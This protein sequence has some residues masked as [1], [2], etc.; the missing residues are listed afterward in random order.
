MTRLG[1]MM[2]VK[3]EAHVIRTC[4]ESVAPL[5]SWWVIADTGSSDGTQQV[6]RDALAG[7]PGELVERPWVDFGHNRQEVLDLARASGHRAPG[8]YVLWIDADEHLEQLP[9]AV[10]ELDLAGYH[11]PVSYGPMRYTRLAVVALDQPWRWVGPIHEYLDLPG[12]PTGEL[13]APVV[14]VEH[15]GARSRDPETYRKDAA[16]IERALLEDPGNPRLEF[17]LAQSWRDAGEPARALAAYETRI[18][19]SAGWE[20]ERW[21]ALLQVGRLREQLEHPPAAVLDAYLAAYQADPR[22]AESLVELARFER[23]RERFESAL[24]F[25]RRA[26]ELPLPTENAL[27]VEA[28][29]YAW[30]AWDELAVSAYWAGHYAEG[31]AAA[32]RALAAEPD[33]PRLQANLAWCREKVDG[34]V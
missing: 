9:D 21:V 26:V 10:P 30:R 33:D 2:I 1:L 23:G 25:A 11:L 24:L 6:V 8:D 14:H 28:A 5:L 7:V 3:D 18:R 29:A 13:A 31:L 27:F 34:A 17:Y 15:T 12:A 22:R 20:Q 4:L 32:S 19:N 16:L